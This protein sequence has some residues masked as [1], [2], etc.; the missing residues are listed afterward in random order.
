MRGNMDNKEAATVL[1]DLSKS[2]DLADDQ[3]EALRKAVELLLLA[4][5][6]EEQVK[7][8]IAKIGEKKRRQ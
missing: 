6:S 4:A 2:A 3:K 5:F 7:K 1:S 8:R